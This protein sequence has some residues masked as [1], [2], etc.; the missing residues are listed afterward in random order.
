[1]SAI[2]VTPENYS[3][4]LSTKLL[5]SEARLDDADCIAR[6]IAQLMDP[7]VAR[8]YRSR[9]AQARDRFVGSL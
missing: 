9:A 7:E 6:A 3:S 5:K 1:M 8:V 4:L 2:T